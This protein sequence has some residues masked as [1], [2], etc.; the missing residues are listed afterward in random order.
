MIVW[1]YDEK[2]HIEGVP[3]ACSRGSLVDSI[4]LPP[5]TLDKYICRGNYCMWGKTV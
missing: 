4:P 5:W 2:L 1:K 3:R